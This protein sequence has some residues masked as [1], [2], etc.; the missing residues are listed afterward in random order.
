MTTFHNEVQ[1]KIKLGLTK[2]TVCVKI[3]SDRQH[4]TVFKCY[5]IKQQTAYLIS[6][7]KLHVYSVLL[8][9]HVKQKQVNIHRYLKSYA[10]LYIQFNFILCS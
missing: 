7:I 10:T 4:T 3:L 1:R 8:C 5:N 9:I 2:W 6:K